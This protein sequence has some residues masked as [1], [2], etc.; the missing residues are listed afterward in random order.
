MNNPCHKGGTCKTINNSY[1]CECFAGYSGTYC[2]KNICMSRPCKNGATC[3]LRNGFYNCKCLH[4]YI[5]TH[6]EAA[7]K[8][9]TSNPCKNGA[10][11]EVIG[12]TYKCRCKPS[13]VGRQCESTR[14][15]C[16]AFLIVSQY[17]QLLSFQL[18]IPTTPPTYGS[19]TVI[20]NTAGTC[21]F[22]R[23]QGISTR[24]T[25]T[26]VA[27]CSLHIQHLCRHSP[28]TLTRRGYAALNNVFQ[29]YFEIYLNNC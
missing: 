6:C 27:E 24:L 18:A 14:V 8:L 3:E 1:T 9:W 12:D 4:G 16:P 5:G 20:P 7:T 21:C 11:I 13:Y 2:E 28:S 19:P 15:I 10:T 17:K 26:E 29:R 22:T 25:S 23:H